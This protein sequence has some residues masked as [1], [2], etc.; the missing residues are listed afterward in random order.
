VGC[1]PGQ[2]VLKTISVGVDVGV[3]FMFK[4]LPIKL[5]ARINKPRPRKSHLTCF[6]S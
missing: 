2:S 6:I 5:Q 4:A 1:G 3:G